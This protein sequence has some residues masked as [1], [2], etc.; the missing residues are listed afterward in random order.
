MG[1][2]GKT[3]FE[4]TTVLNS[5]EPEQRRSYGDVAGAADYIALL[6]PRVMS[7]VI[8]TAF[9]GMIIAPGD[10]HP[11][12]ALAGLISIAMGA[13]ASGAINMWYDAD[14]DA[15][16]TRTRSRPIPRGKIEP[17]E[18]LGFGIT[19]AVGAVIMMGLF[20]NILAAVLLAVTIVFYIVI[21]TMWLKRR[22]PQNIVIGGA[23]GALPPVIGWAV[24]TSDISLDSLILF[25]IIFVWTPPHFWAL[26]LFRGEDYKNVGIPMMPVVAGRGTTRKQ[27]MFYSIVMILV[28]FSP[29]FTGMLG[30]V[31]A[32][33][34]AI[35]GFIFLWFSWQLISIG[36]LSTRPS[37][38]LFGYSIVYLFGL[39]GIMPIDQFIGINF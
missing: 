14:I 2:D 32:V 24:V 8:F 18:S 3:L 39:F 35:L 6:K 15:G 7:L 9:I 16:M 31:Y 20:V 13:G 21:Y 10:I 38:R 27:I 33:T 28:T 1:R 23:A 19:L 37:R 12:I 11:V 17:G 25:A 36:D 34:A 4:N 26:A 29:V 22:T 5:M 30:P